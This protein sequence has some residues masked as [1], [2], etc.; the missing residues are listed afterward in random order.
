MGGFILVNHIVSALDAA[1]VARKRRAGESEARINGR[2]RLTF[3][4]RED[5]AGRT[6]PALTAYRPL[7]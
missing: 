5:S 6:M 1:R 7:Y 4:L 2:T 3:A